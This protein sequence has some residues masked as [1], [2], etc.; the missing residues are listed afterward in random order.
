MQRL[1]KGLRDV[2]NPPSRVMARGDARNSTL[3]AL[4]P[5]HGWAQR[6]GSEYRCHLHSLRRERRGGKLLLRR[7]DTLSVSEQT[8]DGQGQAFL[9]KERRQSRT[10]DPLA[11]V[12]ERENS[13]QSP[14]HETAA[15]TRVPQ[16]STNEMASSVVYKLSL[17]GDTRR[18]TVD[19]DA[20]SYADLSAKAEALFGLP[21][22]SLKFAYTDADGDQITLGSEH[23]MIELLSQK[24][25][26][27]VRLRVIPTGEDSFFSPYLRLVP[28]I[29]SQ[30]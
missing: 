20:L 18:V 13:E 26:P 16:Y 4:D 7:T 6:D 14:V 23:D 2:N 10:R 12:Y 19:R 25:E 5:T 22:D 27:P 30:R 21:A 1:R 8:G 3:A 29:W 28:P 11:P 9:E 24:L 15:S 17:N